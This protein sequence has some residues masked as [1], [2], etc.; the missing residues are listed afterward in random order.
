MT[1]VGRKKINKRPKGNN[2][3]IYY[4]INKRPKANIKQISWKKKE[5]I[6]QHRS[7][8]W[9]MWKMCKVCKLLD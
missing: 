9:K 4:K 5:E 6:I 8:M 2:S 3:T 1:T 7:I